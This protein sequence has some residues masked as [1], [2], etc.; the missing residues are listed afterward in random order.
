MVDETENKTMTRQLTSRMR[1][2]VWV[3]ASPSLARLAD[4]FS[5]PDFWLR[6]TLAFRRRG[7]RLDDIALLAGDQFSL[8]GI[9]ICRLWDRGVS[10]IKSEK[11]ETWED[12]REV[13]VLHFER[14]LEDR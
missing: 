10:V 5:M 7:L 1:G 6:Q 3:P 14:E 11:V 4:W 12:Y 8:Q 9:V 13:A 2:L